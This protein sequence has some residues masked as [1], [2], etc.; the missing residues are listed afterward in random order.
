MEKQN[1]QDELRS[2]IPVSIEAYKELLSK[3]VWRILNQDSPNDIYD[4]LHKKRFLV[5][6]IEETEIMGDCIKPKK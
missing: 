6:R 2:T 4:T 5:K 1:Y 3:D